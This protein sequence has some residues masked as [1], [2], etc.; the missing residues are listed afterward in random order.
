MMGT[1]AKP[2]SAQAPVN[3][4]I[5]DATLFDV[6]WSPDNQLIAVA[7]SWDVKIFDANFEEVAH[8]QGYTGNVLSVSWST[9]S[10]YLASGAGTG[11]GRI[12]VWI[13]D[14]S[15]NAFSIQNTLTT[16]FTA[17]TVV[18]WSPDGSK[19]AS[20]GEEQPQ[21]QFNGLL[22]TVQI[23]NTQDWTLRTNIATQFLFPVPKLQWSLDSTQIAGGGTTY[24]AHENGC[25]GFD[26]T[27]SI[28]YVADVDTGTP[29]RII[30][31]A[32]TVTFAWFAD[33]WLAVIDPYLSI[34]DTATSETT[35][36]DRWEL[37][38]VYSDVHWSTTGNEIAG[39]NPNGSIDVLSA[40]DGNILVS[41]QSAA[42][43]IRLDWSSDGDKLVVITS[44][45]IVEIY[46][47]SEYLSSAESD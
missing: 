16:D 23:W 4:L 5:T 24:C 30:E 10:R 18:S 39:I 2:L 12:V 47:I 31:V 42:G 15:T 27:G 11:D 45:G 19:L 14:L 21:P 34:Y 44:D 46:D 29:I 33:D 7:G 41:I 26:D 38:I 6:A 37:D 25:R 1:W 17:V 28:F 20:I 22:G 36:V 32:E 9:D 8:L 3:Q 35:L 40:T 43:L 13:R